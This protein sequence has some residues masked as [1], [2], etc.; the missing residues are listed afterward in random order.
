MTGG[1]EA[2]ELMFFERG[3][4]EMEF[5][6]RLLAEQDFMLSYRR[7]VYF[8]IIAVAL[9]ELPFGIFCFCFTPRGRLA[10]VTV[11]K[12]EVEIFCLAHH[13]LQ[14]K[15]FHCPLSAGGAESPG[16]LRI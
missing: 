15:L 11:H 4:V 8:L 16:H 6:I 12:A 2:P 7:Q 13:T 5:D 10:D 1:G 14:R 9:L 3:N